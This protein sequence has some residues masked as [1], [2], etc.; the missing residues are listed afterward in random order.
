MLAGT[1][2]FF[3][4]LLHCFP[5][6]VMAESTLPV[7][8]LQAPNYQPPDLQAPEWETP[9]LQAPEWETPKLESPQW[10]TPQLQ[11]PNQGVP[12]LQAPNQGV[13]NLQ[14]PNQGI[15]ELNG[16]NWNIPELQAPNIQAPNGQTPELQAP[17]RNV[18]PHQP[19]DLSTDPQSP[20][21]FSEKKEYDIMKLSIKDMMGGTLTYSADLIQQGEVDLRTGAGKYGF[22]LLQ[23][24][25]K[26]VDIAAKD[27]PLGNVTSLTLD[28]LDAKGAYDSY[29]F[30]LQQN[31]LNTGAN[32][33]T[34]GSFSNAANAANQVRV[35]GL[36]AGLNVG[37]AAI[38]L[39][40]DTYETFS[41]FGQAFDSGLSE[42][43]QNEKFVDGVGALGSTLM[44]AGVIASVIPG[45]QTVAG[46]L[47]ITG[48][49]LWGVSKLV[50]WSDKLSKGAVSRG[51]RDGIGKAVGWM[52]SIFSH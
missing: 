44:D 46:V 40:F 5:I 15:P 13:P 23:V 51:I 31:P 14:A 45:G 38:S 18:V 32:I 30:V 22:F 4:L 35:P 50:K 28:G 12:N 33:N 24:G 21:P 52:K 49:I 3:L 37:V 16:P 27:T 48:G 10:D 17:D 36:V 25:L 9:D 1:F 42:D 39:P 2:A 47:V 43:K 26:G 19:A 11:A 34:L 29:R 7:P 6:I 41:K 8:N 20:E